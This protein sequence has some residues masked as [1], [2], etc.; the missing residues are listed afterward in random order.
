M[1]DT[2][3]MVVCLKVI[4]QLSADRGF[5]AVT[6]VVNPESLVTMLNPEDEYALEMA[7]SLKEKIGNVEIVAISLSPAEDEVVLRRYLAMG[8]DHAIRLWDEGFDALNGQAK[9]FLL[10]EGIRRVEPDLVFCG[11]KALDTNG[12][13]TGGYLAEFLHLPHLSGVTSVE[14]SR[15][16][17]G[18][19]CRRQVESIGCELVET[20]WPVLL[21]VETGDDEPRYPDLFSTLLWL[22]KKIETFDKASLKIDETRLDEWN[23]AVRFLDWNRPKPEK[24]FT[25]KD[26]LPPEERMRL[27]VSG[28]MD[29][30][31]TEFIEGETKAV[32]SQL[33]DLLARKK[34]FKT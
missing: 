19:T 16:G 18:L 22:E 34:L 10:S 8:V 21:S 29:K 26:E 27:I 1:K 25:P 15:E 32:A 20:S 23:S 7:L 6:R 17:G 2:L 33:V 5:D 28:G 12:N 13:E 4:R 11:R 9:A 31:K 3:K 24:V 14:I 30:K